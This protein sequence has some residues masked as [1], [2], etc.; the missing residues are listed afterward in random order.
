ML[1]DARK[2]KKE[3]ILKLFESQLGKKWYDLKYIYIYTHVNKN[4]FDTH[5]KIKWTF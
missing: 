2:E 5:L 1:S 3:N 4:L